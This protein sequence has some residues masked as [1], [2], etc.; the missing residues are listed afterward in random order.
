MATTLARTARAL[1]ERRSEVYNLQGSNRASANIRYDVGIQNEGKI[2]IEIKY[3]KR[4]TKEDG[5]EKSK[6]ERGVPLRKAVS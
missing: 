1:P 3:K 4:E 2:R 5:K 6:V